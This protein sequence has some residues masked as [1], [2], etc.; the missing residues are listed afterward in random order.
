M[1]EE[2]EGGK[3]KLETTALQEKHCHDNAHDGA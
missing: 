1:E 3:P 2:V